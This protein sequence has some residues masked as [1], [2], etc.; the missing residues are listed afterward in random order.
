MG[1]W[2]GVFIEKW[3]FKRKAANELEE[4]RAKVLKKDEK[5]E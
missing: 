5:P 4:K 3:S 2:F 1:E